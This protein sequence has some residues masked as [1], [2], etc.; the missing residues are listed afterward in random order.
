MIE[1]LACSLVGQEQPVTFRP[2]SR[3]AAIVGALSATESF[4]CNYGLGP[5]YHGPLEERGLRITAHGPEGEARA[6]ELD[7]HPFFLGTLYLPQMRPGHPV[8]EAFVA[9]AAA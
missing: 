8:I 7:G 9:A 5:E 2:G 4:Y 1:P 6:V 3:I